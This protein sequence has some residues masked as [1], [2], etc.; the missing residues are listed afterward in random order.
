MPP[1]K[2]LKASQP[3]AA[4]EVDDDAMDID[5][6]SLS[7]SPASPLIGSPLSINQPGLEDLTSY[8]TADQEASLFKATI[9][10]KPAGRRSSPPSTQAFLQPRR[11]PSQPRLLSAKSSCPSLSSMLTRTF[12]PC[13]LSLIGM[14][15][16][17]RMLSIHEHLR[18]HGFDPEIYPHIRIPHI[19]QKL[20]VFYNLDAI[21][22]RENFEEDSPEDR[23]HEFQLPTGMFYGRIMERVLDTDRD[24]SP[25]CLNGSPSPSPPPDSPDAGAHS[26]AP[27]PPQPT[28]AVS[29]PTPTTA[30]SKRKQRRSDAAHLAK[31]TT[32][33]STIGD[34]EDL[35]DAPPRATPKAGARGRAAAAAATATSTRSRTRTRGNAR[36]R[37]AESEDPPSESESKAGEAD[38][39]DS[40]DP[41]EPQSSEEE[42][43]TKPKTTRGRSAGTVRARGKK[44][45]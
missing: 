8:W 28:T 27:P 5:Q 10:W 25:E 19:W 11:K 12:S 4:P 3:S 31:T 29:T 14:H 18:N 37:T 23:Y 42:P 40:D 15:R 34:S 9:R 17:F 32:R 41:E 1:R 22:E 6:A 45:R 26:P 30:T 44:R 35:S 2:K 33:S 43:K 36:R 16:R 7:P 24:T 38:S 21:D 13:L 20:R 39:D